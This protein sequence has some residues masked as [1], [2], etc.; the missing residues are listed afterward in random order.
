MI[1][2]KRQLVAQGTRKILKL[3]TIMGVVN[4]LAIPTSN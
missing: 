2:E 3:P 4:D 1:F